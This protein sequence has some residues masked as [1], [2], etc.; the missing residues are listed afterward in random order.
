[1]S[2]FS[3]LTLL[4][5]LTRLSRSSQIFRF[6]RILIASLFAAALTGC[7]TF[8][9]GANASMTQNSLNDHEIVHG[10]LYGFRW[11]QYHVQKCDDSALA[12]VEF[13]YNWIEL[14]ATIVTVG[15]YLP[16]TVEWWCEDKTTAD[17]EDDPGLDPAN[18][19]RSGN[20]GAL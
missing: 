11:R 10:S 15:L 17:D 20:G 8:E 19:R 2:R 5:R 4:T 16:Q 18:E 13:N 14:L 1:M 9:V 6:T 7:M 12:M 3:Q